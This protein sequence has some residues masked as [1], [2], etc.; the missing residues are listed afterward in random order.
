MKSVK[1]GIEKITRKRKTVMGKKLS[2]G[3]NCYEEKTVWGKAIKL[4]PKLKIVF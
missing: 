2:W 3:K 4:I 1:L